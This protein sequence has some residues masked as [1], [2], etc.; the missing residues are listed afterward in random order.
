MPSQRVATYTIA[1]DWANDGNFTG[2]YDNVT[3]DTLGEP[4][5]SIERGRDQ[6]RASGDVMVPAAS[7]TL[8]NE[9]GT[10]NPQRGPLSSLMYPGRPVKI[11][12][13]MDGDSPMETASLQMDDAGSTMDGGGA[14]GVVWPLFAGTLDDLTISP[15][16]GSRTLQIRALGTL[17][18][19][20][21]RVISTALY[22]GVTTGQAMVHL[23]TAAG[24]TS[25]GYVIDTTSSAGWR[26]LT[27]WWV[28]EQDAYD[29]AVQLLETEGPPAALYEDGQGRVVFE[30]RLYRSLTDRS[31]TAQAT[32][33]DTAATDG[34]YY[35][36]ISYEPGLRDIVNDVSL[37]LDVRTAAA[38]RSDVWTYGTT[39]SLDASGAASV[40]ARP[41]DP[42]T[43]A[44]VP[45][46]LTDFTLSTG[47][48]TVAL[49][50]TSGGSTLISFSGG[51]A[52]ATITGLK[53]RAKSVPVT[54]SVVLRNAVT[55]SITESQTRYGVRSSTP[56]VI[57]TLSLTEGQLLANAITD[58]YG[59]LRPIATI[60][61]ANAD[62]DHETQ[63]LVREVSDRIHVV[64]STLGIDDDYTVEQITHE[65][66]TAGLHTVKLGLE[67]APTV[68]NVG[69]W[70]ASDTGTSDWGDSG[71]TPNVG[72]WG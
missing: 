47:T 5:L 8:S 60:T 41:N 58:S 11:Q 42:F 54:S 62:G 32:F 16:L 64:S 40:L 37:T 55:A 15:D 72:I 30:S 4:G 43:D 20:R 23:L 24:I 36:S 67:K 69:R 49:S 19:L 29:A 35:Q 51:T 25:T 21:G 45:V 17:L 7:W 9:A 33:R 65:V 34:Y 28:D 12:A 10:Y 56:D 1:V 38:A 70:L 61:F 13:G 31:L 52:G 27:W 2:T 18:K 50:R 3:A 63:A 53:L 71:S 46:V 48:V 14:A 68:A 59:Q 6:Q 22:A 26:T 44:L 66:K 39:L 57:R